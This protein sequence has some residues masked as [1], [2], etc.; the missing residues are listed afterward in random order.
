MEAAHTG[1][2]T[3]LEV[4]TSPLEVVLVHSGCCHKTSPDW[5][6]TTT[7]ICSSQFWKWEV[8]DQGLA[9]SVPG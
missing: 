5:V 2:D 8:Q 9:D 1:A 3:Q 6:G 7:H 4:L